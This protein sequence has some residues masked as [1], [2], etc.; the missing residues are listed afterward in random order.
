MP[1]EIVLEDREH[2]PRAQ[3]SHDPQVVRV[4]TGEFLETNGIKSTSTD[5]SPRKITSLCSVDDEA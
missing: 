4:E 5:A 1:R 3:V 2:H